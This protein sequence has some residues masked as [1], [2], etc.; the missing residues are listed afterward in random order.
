MLHSYSYRLAEMNMYTR[1]LLTTHLVR[2]TA[3]TKKWGCDM[4]PCWSVFFNL[5]TLIY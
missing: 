4:Y 3:L 2:G 1:Q 5:G